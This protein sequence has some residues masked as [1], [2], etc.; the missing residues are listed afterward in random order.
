VILAVAVKFTAVLLLPFLLIAARPTQRRLRILLGAGLATVP[1]V[2]LSLALFG[3]SL[4]N[5]H[6]QATLLTSF[7][8]P[9]WA[10]TSSAS[11]AARRR[12]CVWRTSRWCWVVVV[13]LRRGRDWVS[14]AGWA[15]LALIAS[16]AWV[17]PWYVI[18][19]LPL[20]ALGTS[21]RLRRAAVA[22]SVYL[23]VTFVPLDR[24]HPRPAAHRP[25]EGLG[26]TGVDDSAE[27]ALA[28]AELPRADSRHG[29]DT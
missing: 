9:M 5:L 3:F 22:L 4:P 20:A 24:V 7:S 27:E 21:V 29:L 15:T 6:D 26:G 14:G 10:A 18:G 13:L 11:A 16:L 23:V 28:V 2:A 17:I 12:C 1:M 8:I 19:L 25:A